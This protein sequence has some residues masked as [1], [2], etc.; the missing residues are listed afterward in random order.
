[1]KR[2][3]FGFILGFITG[4]SCCFFPQPTEVM[5][6]EQEDISCTAAKAA[7]SRVCDCQIVCYEERK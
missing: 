6:I 7:A 2:I 5:C 3:F 4:V 1:M